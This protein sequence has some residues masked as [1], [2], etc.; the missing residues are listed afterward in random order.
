MAIIR[1]EL[2]TPPPRTPRRFKTDRSINFFELKEK[3]YRCLKV[4][5]VTTPRQFPV[6]AID[7]QIPLTLIYFLLSISSH[8]QPNF[9]RKNLTGVLRSTGNRN[10]SV[11][12]F[13]ESSV[14]RCHELR[15]RLWIQFAIAAA[16]FLCGPQSFRAPGFGCPEPSWQRVPRVIQIPDHRPSRLR[17]YLEGSG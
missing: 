15:H 6:H 2:K 3:G 13:R 11:S 10:W 5:V 4:G 7:T 14:H 16:E 1:L 17:T 8:I 12:F 9:S